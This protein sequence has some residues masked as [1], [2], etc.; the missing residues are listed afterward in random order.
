MKLEEYEQILRTGTPTDRA[1]AIAAASDDKELSE[2]EFHQLTALIKGA[3]RPRARKMT[4]DEIRGR[5]ELETGNVI[6]ETFRDKAP[7]DIPAVL[8]HSHGPFCW[9]KDPLNAVHNAVVLEEI[10]FMTWHNQ[11]MD[12]AVPVMQQEL[13]DKHYLRKHGANAYYGQGK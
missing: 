3:V 7:D 13:L 1:R 9:G 2:E 10:A 8:V 11:M 5:Y 12:P 6:V 4:P